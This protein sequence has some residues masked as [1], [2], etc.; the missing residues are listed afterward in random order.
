MNQVAVTVID[1][2]D[3]RSVLVDGADVFVRSAPRSATAQR[4]HFNGAKAVVLPLPEAAGQ[5]KWAATLQPLV[6]TACT[7]GGEVSICLF[8]GEH[9]LRHSFLTAEQGLLQQLVACV[10]AATGSPGTRLTWQGWVT[11]ARKPADLLSGKVLDGPERGTSAA[12]MPS[13]RS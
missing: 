7:H 4:F 6:D 12:R 8:G 11:G 9:T 10:A 5:S 3:K 1:G 13:I 2:G